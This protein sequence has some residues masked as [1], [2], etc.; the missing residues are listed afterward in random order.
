[1]PPGNTSAAL[2]IIKRGEMFPSGRLVDRIDAARQFHMQQQQQQQQQQIYQ[3]HLMQ[4]SQFQQQQHSNPIMPPQQRP[5]S[6]APGYPGTSNT[7]FQQRAAFGDDILGSLRPIA[8]RW[9]KKK[10]F[11]FCQL[12][13][14]TFDCFD[15]IWNFLNSSLFLNFQKP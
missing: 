14:I 10:N 7:A 2:E 9:L 4:N 3:Q 1:M 6:A 12:N 8:K 11:V 5:F 15:E 13:R